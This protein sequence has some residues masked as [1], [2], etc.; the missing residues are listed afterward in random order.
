MVHLPSFRFL[1]FFDD[2]LAT[3]CI[4]A[5][6]AKELVRLVVLPANAKLFRNLINRNLLMLAKECR[7]NL[8]EVK[9]VEAL[10]AE[11]LLVVLTVNCC[12]LIT[13]LLTHN[14]VFFATVIDFNLGFDL[15]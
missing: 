11:I 4:A 12:L 2:A 13:V 15:M 5:A 14:G 7:I 8:T 9:I 10:I 6:V 3:K 1:H